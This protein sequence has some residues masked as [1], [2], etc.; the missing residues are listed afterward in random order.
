[1]KVE[2][3][4][5]RGLPPHPDADA[6]KHTEATDGGDVPL[7]AATR[8]AESF[9][10]WLKARRCAAG[11]SQKALAMAADCTASY[12]SLLESAKPDHKT[13][14]PIHPTLDVLDRIAG[15]LGVSRFEARLAAYVE[16]GV[17]EEEA[18]LLGLYRRLPKK[19]RD[20]FDSYVTA[21]A[22]EHLHSVQG[23]PL[24]SL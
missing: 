24:I 6:S 1:M 16:G 19:S 22:S 2:R 14:K 4:Q 8:Q 3:K 21:L 17:S 20:R 11:I 15:A 23:S 7:R 5:H 13:G 10:R 12:I 9:A 18:L